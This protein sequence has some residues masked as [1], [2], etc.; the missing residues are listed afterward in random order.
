M[1]VKTFTIALL[2][3]TSP[4]LQ[5]G[6]LTT[7][8][9]A[10]L[11]GSGIYVA[12]GKSNTDTTPRIPRH[13]DLSEGVLHQY[14]PSQNLTELTNDQIFLASVHREIERTEYVRKV[15]HFNRTL[16]R[17]IQ[18]DKEALNRKQAGYSA[19]RDVYAQYPELCRYF[20]NPGVLNTER[21]S[22]PTNE[23]IEA[24]EEF[25]KKSKLTT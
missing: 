4:L 3:T 13:Y 20:G 2:L 9:T 19:I 1:N 22:S 17:A 5:A 24:A 16:M 11:F 18:A 8:I 7:A 21:N 14:V 6:W 25:V 15:N 23:T 10:G 12:G